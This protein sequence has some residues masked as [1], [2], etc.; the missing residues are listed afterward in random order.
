MDTVRF[1]QLVAEL[2]AL[3]KANPGAL[4]RRIRWLV[5]LGYAFVLGFLAVVVALLVVS[6]VLV[7]NTGRAAAL[8][9]PII[10]LAI[11]AFVIIRALW[12][13]FDDP[14]GERITA[15]Q[16]PKL[17]ARVEQIRS[18]LRAPKPDVVI[19]DDAFNASVTQIPRFGVFGGHRVYLRIGLPLMYAMGPRQLDAVLGHEFGHLS[20]AH[21]KFGLWVIRV[22]AVWGR[23]LHDLHQNG[24][25]F[26]KLIAPFFRWYMP[27]LDAHG[28]ALGREDEYAADR[29]GAETTDAK[30]MAEALATLEVRGTAY[31]EFWKAIGTRVEQEP[32]PPAKNWTTLPAFFAQM[33]ADARRPSWMAE[34]MARENLVE[35]THPAF[36]HRLAALDMLPAPVPDAATMVAELVPPL[37]ATAAEHYLGGLARQRLVAWEQRWTRDNAA[38]WKEAHAERKKAREALNALVARDLAGETLTKDELYDAAFAIQRLD[39]LEA[40]IPYLERVIAIDPSHAAAH[41]LLGEA[42]IAQRDARGAELVRR[43]MDLEPAAIPHGNALLRRFH[44]DVG[45]RDAVARVDAAATA[46]FKKYEEVRT[47]VLTVDSSVQLGPI[48]FS[49]DERKK[50]LEAARVPGV[51]ALHL[52]R[53]LTKHAT[54]KPV[55][56]VLVEPKSKLRTALGKARAEMAEKV[57]DVLQLPTKECFVV[58]Y[59][60]STSWL[61]RRI[62]KAG[63]VLVTPKGISTLKA[64]PWYLPGKGLRVAVL[65]LAL[66]FTGV[67]AWYKWPR[68]YADLVDDPTGVY[69]TAQRKMW[70][71]VLN[72]VLMQT[73]VEVHVV[74][75]SFP[76]GT[77]MQRLATDLAA[78]RKFGEARHQQLMLV[79]DLAGARGAFANTP[80]LPLPIPA[81]LAERILR[82]HQES[83]RSDLYL[84]AA[85]DYTLRHVIRVLQSNTLGIAPLLARRPALPDTMVIAFGDSTE[86]RY[87][88]SD[89]LKVYAPR[90][91]RLDTWF[92]PSATPEEALERFRQWITL[93]VWTPRAAMF[94]PETRELYE[95]N[96][97]AS[98]AGWELLRDE[99]LGTPMRVETSGDYAA[100]IATDDPLVQPIFFRKSGDVWL[101]DG[102][103]ALELVPPGIRMAYAWGLLESGGSFSAP[104]NSLSVTRSAIR[105]FRNGANDPLPY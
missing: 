3:S 80:G 91:A 77:D 88:P 76:A 30:A 92:A 54:S 41:Y 37:Q 7:I 61:V 18:A 44:A 15:K 85:T 97:N 93:P 26:G 47:E 27:R 6:V 38:P 40:A 43:A 58:G 35:D 21:P 8:W 102:V 94:T 28:F 63:G 79:L 101:M 45:D 62:R 65:T 19:L 32:T 83:V 55:V 31:G 81:P 23:L 66:A 67:Y 71:D 95:R 57:A 73:G 68:N 64:R 86:F 10:A 89:P 24:S 59:D 42:L 16:A 2:E 12:V 34:A 96:W 87:S 48:S 78:A 39:S 100:A 72:S 49:A 53:R 98:P 50:L 82:G 4:R 84:A 52:A 17:F 13:K 29:D 90:N 103:A 14:T 60:D 105:R 74:V 1:N 11:L 22:S 70:G 33:E 20:G 51:G 9:K 25:W 5:A 99:Y 75:D 69:N 56:V 104:M 46:D 36:R